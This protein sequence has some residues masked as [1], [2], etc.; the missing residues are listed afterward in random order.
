MRTAKQRAAWA[1]L[2]S[3]VKRMIRKGPQ[4]VWAKRIKREFNYVCAQCQ[5]PN[6]L[7]AHHI[8]FKALY[9]SRREDLDNGL[10]LCT[11]CHDKIHALYTESIPSYFVLVNQLMEKREKMKSISAKARN[12]SAASYIGLYE[13]APIEEQEQEPVSDEPKL[14]LK[15][16]AEPKKKKKLKLE[17]N[18]EPSTEPGATPLTPKIETKPRRSRKAPSKRST[19]P[20]S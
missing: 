17:P 3:Y 9:P 15:A 10:C 16:K 11:K 12:P 19:K 20:K 2:P 13:F 8:F 1:K 6:S 5:S 14:S 7:E 4:S 18:T